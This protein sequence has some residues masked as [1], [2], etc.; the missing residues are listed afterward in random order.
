[1]CKKWKI[2]EKNKHRIISAKN[3]HKTD[4]YQLTFG[5]SFERQFLVLCNEAR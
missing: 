5:H 3:T 4:N 1:L 2:D